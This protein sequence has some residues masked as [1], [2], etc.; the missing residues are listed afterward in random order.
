MST[1]SVKCTR[2]Q[3]KR[4]NPEYGQVGAYVPKK[5][6][7]AVKKKLLNESNDFSELITELLSKWVQG[8]PDGKP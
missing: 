2:V 7:K 3:G 8:L 5:L 1:K 6:Y 4:S